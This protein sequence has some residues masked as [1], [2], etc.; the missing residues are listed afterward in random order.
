MSCPRCGAES[1]P[2]QGFC[3]N[4]GAPSASGESAQIAAAAA[5]AQVVPP[6]APAP[7]AA[8]TTL[9]SPIPDGG[10]TVEEVAAWLEREG[11]SAKFITGESGKRHI[12]SST[13]GF[14]L[15]IFFGD[16]K[17]ERCACLEL[18]TGFATNG[19]FDIS[20]INAWNY[21]NRWCRAY[22]DDVNDPWL[23]MNIDLWP[24][25]TYES[26]NDLFATWNRMLGQ[27]IEEYSLR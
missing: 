20:Q 23:K 14:P 26:L 8:S 5:A 21:N 4:C 16:C 1:R 7:P 25:G 9:M 3:S 15:N 27:F 13:Q 19:K 6:P 22:Y 11:Y 10:L 17:A 2:D 18:A 12:E 24:G